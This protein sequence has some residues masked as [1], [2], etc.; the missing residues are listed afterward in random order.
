MNLESIIGSVVGETAVKVQYSTRLKK[1]TLDQL[2]ECARRLT[3]LA[4][5]KKP[6]AASIVIETAIAELHKTLKES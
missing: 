2:D 1:E 4:D 3:V 5:Q 6:L